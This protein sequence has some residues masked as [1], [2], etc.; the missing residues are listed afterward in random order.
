M[1]SLMLI[2]EECFGAERFSA[3]IVR[4]FVE[5]D[6]TFVLAA[7]EEGELI[8]SA[9]CVASE[10]RREGK[11]A[12]IAVRKDFRR[13]GVGSGLLAE[14]EKCFGRLGA[15]RYSLEVEASNSAAV[16]LYLGEGYEVKATLSDFYGPGR[17]ALYM[18]KSVDPSRR[19]IRVRSV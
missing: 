8:G 2:E 17:N 18:E 6:D 11:I 3:E 14:C 16:S 1:P 4:A 13:K 19:E 10:L 12:S 5:R 7:T 9:M 15:L